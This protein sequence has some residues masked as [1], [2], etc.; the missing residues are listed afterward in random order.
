MA[1]DSGVDEDAVVDRRVGQARFVQRVFAFHNNGRT[2]G[3]SARNRFV[4]DQL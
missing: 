3:S 2:N 1:E 4:L